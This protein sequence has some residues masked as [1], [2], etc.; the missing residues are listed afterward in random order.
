V[1]SATWCGGWS[2]RN[3][4]ARVLVRAGAEDTGEVKQH[5]DQDDDHDDDGHQQPAITAIELRIVVVF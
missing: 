5:E 1:E 3:R 4:A 2:V